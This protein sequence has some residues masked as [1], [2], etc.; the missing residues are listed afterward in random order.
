MNLINKI[1]HKDLQKKYLSAKPF[2]HI[3]IDNFFK[4]DFALKLE[5]EFPDFN[6]KTWYLYDNPIENKKTLNHWD[7]FP[8]NTYQAFS[9]LNNLE[10][11]SQ[12]EKLT[13]IDK[14]YPDIG[15]NGGGWHM[16]GRGGKLNVHLDYSI[17]PKL[18][19]ERRLN[20][21]IY[22]CKDWQENWGGQLGLWSH[23]KKN[24]KP[25]EC[26]HKISPIFN[27][28]VIFDTTQ[29]SWY[30]LPE[31]IKCPEGAYRKSLAIYYLSQPRKE[32]SKRGKALFAPYQEQEEDQEI[33]E[34][35]KKDRK[36]L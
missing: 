19:L 8:K 25:K 36:F 31:E 13:S 23:D 30:G 15:L 2:H 17:H 1:N 16:H 14:L 9:Y 5:A 27:R 21:I 18:F 35:I 6:D 20:I 22:L 33:L 32:A 3:V 4:E 26:I 12:I 34:L 29:N 28:A 7:R 24:Q 10:F 11:I